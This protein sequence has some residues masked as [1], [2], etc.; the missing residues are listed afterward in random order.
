MQA[1]ILGTQNNEYTCDINITRWIRFSG[2]K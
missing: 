2:E 1:L